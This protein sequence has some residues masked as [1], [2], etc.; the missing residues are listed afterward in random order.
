MGKIFNAKNLPLLFL[1]PMDFISLFS[2]SGLKGINPLI[3]L[4]QSLTN[5]SPYQALQLHQSRE[6]F[7]FDSGSATVPV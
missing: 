4:F 6:I 2:P 5:Q 3:K 1:A 7:W